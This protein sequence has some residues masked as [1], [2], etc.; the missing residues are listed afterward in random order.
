MTVKLHYLRRNNCAFRLIASKKFI[1]HILTQD[2][3]NFAYVIIR[4]ATS[5][6]S[7][8]CNNLIRITWGGCNNMCRITWGGGGGG[9]V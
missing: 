3:F 7:Q 6:N 2:M 9:G 8:G 1:Y 4:N 5:H